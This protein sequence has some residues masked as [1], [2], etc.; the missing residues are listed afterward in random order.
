MEVALPQHTDL[1]AALRPHLPWHAARVGFLAAF[2]LALIKV[3]TVGLARVAVCLNPKAAPESNERRCRRFLARF[4]YAQGAL[5]RL[6]L[7]FFPDDL[8]LSLDRTEWHLGKAAVNVLTLGVAHQGVAFP[9]AWLGLGKA[10]ASNSS[11]RVE[12]FGPVLDLVRQRLLAVTADREFASLEFLAFLVR[13]RLPFVLR[14]KVNTLASYKGC[15][16]KPELWFACLEPGKTMWLTK[17]VRVLRQRVF[18]VAHRLEDGE[19][20]V[21]ITD[22]CLSRAVLTYAQRWEIECL[23]GAL[24]SRGF[25]FESTHVTDPDR[26]ERLFGLLAVALVWAHRVGELVSSLKPIKVKKHGRRAVSVFRYGL[27]HLQELLL[28][29]RS[30]LLSWDDAIRVLSGT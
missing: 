10:G 23:Y 24:K 6:V 25:D 29:G 1:V 14:V 3:R 28:N 26:I 7:G 11:E 21:L 13:E 5:A 22:R 17:P 30:K 15:T 18:L 9:L 16:A 12:V 8:V 19:L 27:D 20:L 2:V 4:D